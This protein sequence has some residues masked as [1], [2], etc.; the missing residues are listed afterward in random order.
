[1][2]EMMEEW[3]IVHKEKNQYFPTG[4]NIEVWSEAVAY[5]ASLEADLNESVLVSI[6]SIT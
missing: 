1:M 4:T 2:M 5:Q 3:G 6:G